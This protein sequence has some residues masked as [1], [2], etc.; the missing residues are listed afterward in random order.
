MLVRFGVW[1]SAGSYAM[2]FSPAI[3]L[4]IALSSADVA[5]NA[6]QLPKGDW[7]L[8]EVA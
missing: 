8:T 7:F 2:P 3:A 6:Q 5:P 4:R 1:W